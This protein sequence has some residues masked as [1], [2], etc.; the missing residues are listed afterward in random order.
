MHHLALIEYLRISPN[1]FSNEIFGFFLYSS[2]MFKDTIILLVYYNIALFS[3]L[4]IYKNGIINVLFSYKVSF[5]ILLSVLY[6]I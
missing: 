3:L 2:C 4:K 6:H 1:S 5:Y